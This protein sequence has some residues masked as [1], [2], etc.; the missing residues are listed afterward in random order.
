MA[1]S[2][3]SA[4]GRPVRGFTLIELM[5]AVA[6]V[7]ILASVA[8]PSYQ[9]YVARSNRSVAI[10]YLNEVATRQQQYRLDARTFGSLADIGMS[11][12]PSD[13]S[14]HYTI[15]LSGAATATTFTV[16]AAPKGGQA[17]NDSTCG[18]LTLDQAGAKTAS[19]S[20]GA[21]TCWGGR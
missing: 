9:R 14:T 6:I 21:A 12:A 16:Q 20:A 4:F 8:Y 18:T 15:S 10:A 17:T 2:H 5:I 19:G 3:Q 11:S 1:T 13:V 7:G